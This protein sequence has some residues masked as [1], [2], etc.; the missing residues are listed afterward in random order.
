[1]PA[2]F[3]SRANF[4]ERNNA[5]PSFQKDFMRKDEVDAYQK[6]ANR[7]VADL[8]GE[9][10]GLQRLEQI[11]RAQSFYAEDTTAILTEHANAL[12]GARQRIKDEWL[13]C[14]QEAAGPGAKRRAEKEKGHEAPAPPV[15]DDAAA[16][17]K[18]ASQS[19]DP[20]A[21][22]AALLAEFEAEE[23]A[24]KPLK[25]VTKQRKQVK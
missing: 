24:R 9:V 4:D 16:G 15:C 13:K 25:L 8:D 2:F 17:T 19:P 5:D 18:G 11:A 20:Y 12:E 3:D 21:D 6:A 7:R 22:T 1:M 10:T 23:E 14:V